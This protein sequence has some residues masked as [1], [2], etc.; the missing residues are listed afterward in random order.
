[1][2]KPAI[3]KVVQKALEERAPPHENDYEFIE[4]W[5]KSENTGKK[6]GTEK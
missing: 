1:M 2:K 3:V 4:T 6:T 5:P